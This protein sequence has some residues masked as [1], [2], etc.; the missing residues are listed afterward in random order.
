[1][2]FQKLAVVMAGKELVC[3]NKFGRP[4]VGGVQVVR[5]C[6]VPGR[7][8]AT[9]LQSQLLGDCRTGND[10]GDTWE[11]LPGKQLESARLS[12]RSYAVH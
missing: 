11:N 7:F 8:Q 3:V 10:R 4:L 1:M 2:D 5:D 9:P 6:T 12:E